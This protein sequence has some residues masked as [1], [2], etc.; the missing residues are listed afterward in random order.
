MGR[1]DGILLCT[2][3]D[4]T[5]FRDDKTVSRENL[6]AIEHFKREGGSFAFITGRMPFYVGKVY[7]IVRPNV[8]YGCANGGAV[9]DGER[10][11]YVHTSRMPEGALDLIAA[12][13]EHFPHIG[14]EVSTYDT[15]Y[16]YRDNKMM[17]IFRQITRLPNTRADY[18]EI[19]EPI[20]KVLLTAD[21]PEEILTLGEFLCAHP[22]AERF[23]LVSSESHLFEVEPKEA[24]KGNGLAKMAAHL[25]IDMK[26]TVA[27]GD[28]DNDVTMLRAAGVGVAVANASPAALAAADRVTVSNEEHALARVIADIERGEIIL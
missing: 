1:F 24:Q 17:E 2:D 7:D 14:I 20:A 18:R 11:V 13:E 6:D 3:L 8:P 25:G 19:T 27:V 28:Y 5:L 22:L 12:V 9:Y 21:H 15:A 4:G 26:R 16:F 10:G 23:A